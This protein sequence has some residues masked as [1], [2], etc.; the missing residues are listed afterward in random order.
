MIVVTD[1][2]ALYAGFDASQPDH[3]AA[4]DVMEREI[5]VI[6]PIVLTELDH[7]V[8]RDLGSLPLC[9]SPIH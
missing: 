7:L 9:R 8:H 1:T 4:L 5:L 3:V 6:S 2:S